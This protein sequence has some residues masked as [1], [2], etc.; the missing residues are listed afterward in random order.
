MENHSYDVAP[1]VLIDEAETHLHYDAQADLVNVFTTQSLAAKVIYTT[2]SA[3]CLPQDLGNGVRAVV[4][5]QGIERSTVR[6]SIWVDGAVGFSPLVY[7]MGATAF[8]FLPARNVLIGEGAIDAMLYP[9]LF[10][11]AS[12][13]KSLS[14]QVVPGLAETAPARFLSLGAEGGTVG[15][16]ADGDQD[17]QYYQRELE[18]QGIDADV[19]FGLD[20]I[21]E[22]SLTLEDLIDAEHFCAAINM[23]LQTYQQATFMYSPSDLP[24]TERM[25][26]LARWCQSKG[27]S[28][29]D[30]RD[31]AQAL[32]NM[33]SE[34]AREASELQLIDT[35]SVSQFKEL[36]FAIEEIFPMPY[37]S[38]F[39]SR[40]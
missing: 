21:F 4:P 30:K 17:G 7:A 13:R 39:D 20:K 11:E 19:I 29:I 18:R 25:A 34:A 33:K 22:E 5:L 8:A 3:G 31:L 36:Y 37:P 40:P 15:F 24:K 6:N 28:P 27:L 38:N 16:I 23:L 35:N 12:G 26:T 32:L 14:F 10:R 2:H 1:I 9:T